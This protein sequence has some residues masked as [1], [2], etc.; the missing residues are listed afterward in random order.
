MNFWHAIFSSADLPV[1]K[2]VAFE[3]KNLVSLIFMR[4]EEEKEGK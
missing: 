4:K 2:E 3:R 1:K